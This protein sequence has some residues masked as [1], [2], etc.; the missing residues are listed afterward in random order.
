MSRILKRWVKPFLA[1]LPGRARGGAGKGVSRL[2]PGFSRMG[3]TEYMESFA[4]IAS[5][6]RPLPHSPAQGERRVWQLWL[7]GEDNAP[8]VVRM[9]IESVR[10][11]T[12]PLKHVLLDERNYGEY[13]ELPEHIVR[14]HESGEM[15][16]ASFADYLRIAL[17][18][19]YGGV[20]VDA[21]VLITA[22]VPDEILRSDFFVFSSPLWSGE[23]FKRLTP[24][25]IGALRFFSDRLSTTL[26]GSSWWMCASSASPTIQTTKALLDEYWSRGDRRRD[27]MIIYDL[28]SL[29]ILENP[30]C[31]GEWQRMPKRVTTETQLLRSMLREKYDAE[32]MDALLS[33]SPVHKLVHNVRFEVSGTFMG[34]ILEEWCGDGEG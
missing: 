11:H 26:F 25:M 6:T 14:L 22:P 10:R 32:V 20:W 1:K 13:V 19:K 17:L 24:K 8:P 5:R 12:K 18:A 34:H 9:C 31:R 7:Q 4:D 33:L 16:H 2:A 29:A 30:D 15:S 3:M 23:S 27:Y 21:T 28:I